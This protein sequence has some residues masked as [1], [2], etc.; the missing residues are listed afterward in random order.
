MGH[1]SKQSFPGALRASR[2]L[3]RRMKDPAAEKALEAEQ[4][5]ILKC[6]GQNQA[7][8]WNIGAS[9]NKI[10]GEKLAERSGFKTAQ[11]YFDTKLK[12][13]ARSTL[14]A[15]GRVAKMFSLAIAVRYGVSKLNLLLTWCKLRKVDV[16]QADPGPMVIEVPREGGA[17]RKKPFAEVSADELRAAL[18]QLKGPA[19]VP[20]FPDLD[21]RILEGIAREIESHRRDDFQ[22]R[23]KA[24]SR[25]GK[26]HFSLENIS[27]VYV[28]TVVDLVATVVWNE[29]EKDGQTWPPQPST[30]G[31]EAATPAGPAAPVAPGERRQRSERSAVPPAGASRQRPAPGAGKASRP[32]AAPARLAAE[33]RGGGEGRRGSERSAGTAVA[34]SAG[35]Q[36][37]SVSSRKRTPDRASSA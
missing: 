26:A 8:C 29:R 3:Q 7:E 17:P 22:V 1:N 21:R 24:F 5:T 36:V 20:D 28:N 16:V 34:T 12:V 10:V 14:S 4:L 23:F 32:L 25:N 27:L 31:E 33:A 11:E 13:I 30:S 2:P 6:F 15:Y 37:S 9:Y 19:P 35:P 18:R